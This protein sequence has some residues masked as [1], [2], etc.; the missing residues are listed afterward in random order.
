MKGGDKLASIADK[1]QALMEQHNVTAYEIAK[2]IDYTAPAV[3]SWAN[4][5]LVP[6]AKAIKELSAF[7]NVPTNYFMDD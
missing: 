3:Y 4:G 2:H 1:L 7:F 5:T 6:K